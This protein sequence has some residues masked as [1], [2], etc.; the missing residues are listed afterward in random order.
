MPAVSSDFSRA[1]QAVTAI[2]HFSALP[3]NVIEVLAQ[4]MIPRTYSAGQVICLEGEAGEY[5]YFL[6]KG[7]VKGVCTATDGR[8]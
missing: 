2:K 8:E 5:V 3:D 4:R 7:W 1:K 6:E